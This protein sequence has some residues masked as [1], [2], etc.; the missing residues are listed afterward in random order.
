MRHLCS[1][2]PEQQKIAVLGGS[3]AAGGWLHQVPVGPLPQPRVTEL[4][5]QPSP[6]VLGVRAHRVAGGV[7]VRA[8]RGTG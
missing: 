1:L 3:L 7:G 4:Q 6:L 8:A 5:H 2:V